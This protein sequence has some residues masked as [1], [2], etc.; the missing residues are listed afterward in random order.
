MPGAGISEQCAPW[1]NPQR[2]RVQRLPGNRRRH[3]KVLLQA[4]VGAYPK[5]RGHNRV[6]SIQ[7]RLGLSRRQWR[8]ED[9]ARQRERQAEAAVRE[10]AEAEERARQLREVNEQRELRRVARLS[11][12]MAAREVL[13]LFSSAAQPSFDCQKYAR[14]KIR[15]RVAVSDLLCISPELAEA[16][17]LMGNAYRVYRSRLT[18]SGAVWL[19]DQQRSWIRQRNQLCPLSFKDLLVAPRREAAVTCLRA[20]TEQRMQALL[21]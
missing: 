1:K 13:L 9:D 19:R 4:L 18:S 3:V 21:Q 8:A 12:R 14:S 7:T 17:K 11:R 16:D 10:Q 2:T 15:S 5:A 20:A 6:R